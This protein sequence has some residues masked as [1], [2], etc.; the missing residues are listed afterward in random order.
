[1]MQSRKVE[2]TK[3][4]GMINVSTLGAGITKLYSSRYECE[5]CRQRTLELFQF[6]PGVSSVKLGEDSVLTISYDSKV[7]DV[8]QL[9]EFAQKALQA[10][11]HNPAPVSLV[12]ADN[13]PEDSSYPLSSE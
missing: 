4:G 13:F 6:V 12:F 10:D 11:P 9:A 2:T 3:I 8:K 5:G 7:I 1:M